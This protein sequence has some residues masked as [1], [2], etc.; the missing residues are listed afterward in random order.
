ML[1]HCNSHVKCFRMA[2]DKLKD[3]V[4][5]DVKLKL[6]SNKENDGRIY[7]IPIVSEVAALITGDSDIGLTRDIILE[8]QTE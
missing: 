8:T 6:I 4:V 1:D 3:E 2:R 5:L 7:N